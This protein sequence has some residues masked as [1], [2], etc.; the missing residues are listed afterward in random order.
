MDAFEALVEAHRPA[1]RMV[2]AKLVRLL[3]ARNVRYVIGGANALSLYVRPRMTVDLDAFV[4]A[5]EK[6]TL[7][8]LLAAD[9]EVLSVG[10][11]H[12][13]FRDGDVEVDIVCAGANAEDFAIASGR[14]AVLLGTKVRVASPEGLL[15]LYLNSEK[16]VNFADA[17]ELLRSQPALDLRRVRKQ[18]ERHQPELLAKL[19]KMLHIARQ[20]TPSYEESR[21]RRPGELRP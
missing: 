12:S 11:F 4:D 18:L 9:F 14:D 2:L 21:A 8:K 15:L 16:P 17:I 19:E 10:R 20:P 5:S 13:K 7:D 3:E 6:E 1:M